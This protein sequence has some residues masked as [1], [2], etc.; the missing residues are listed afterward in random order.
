MEN[1]SKALLIAGSILIAVLL[2][3]FGMRIFTSTSGT[4]DQVNEAMTTMEITTFNSQFTSYIGNNKNRAQVISLLNRI[5]IS[6]SKNTTHQV[7]VAD[8]SG[9]DIENIIDYMNGL[10]GNIYTIEI[11]ELDSNGYIKVIKIY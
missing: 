1:A 8:S 7:G 10:T 6:N 2:I 4:T 9:T 3:A 5:I 11:H